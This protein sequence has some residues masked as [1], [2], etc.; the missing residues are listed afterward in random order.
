MDAADGEQALA[1]LE[2]NQDIRL[3]ITDYN[4]P[5]MD[6]FQLTTAIRKDHDWESI[7]IIGLSAQGSGSLSAKF[8]KNGANDFLSKPFSQEEF[9]CRVMQNIEALEH[10]EA[11]RDSAKRDYLTKLYNRRFFFSVAESLYADAQKAQTPLSVAMIDI[12]HF[13]LINDNY[14]H[15]IGDQVLLHMAEL[16]NDNLGSYLV[17]RFGGE[18]FCVLLDSINQ[19]EASQF[20]DK[21]RQKIEQSQVSFDDNNIKYT[22][23][24]G[25][26]DDV[27]NDLD[28][29]IQKADQA[30]YRAKHGGRNQV[31]I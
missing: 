1:V 29:L 19:S 9:Y 23:S 10:I 30:L 15:D 25:I 3:V 21:F 31:V 8:I 18:E 28:D 2:N 4:M 6:G 14:G 7:A 13:K 11:I 16:L 22:I 26:S 12:D 20:L 24:I 17:A 5:K 27:N